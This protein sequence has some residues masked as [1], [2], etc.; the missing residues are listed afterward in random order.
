MITLD[1]ISQ[2]RVERG[3]SERLAD[4]QTLGLI[5]CFFGP[6]VVDITP[7]FM[8]KNSVLDHIHGL[9]IEYIAGRKMSSIQLRLDIPEAVEEAF[10]QKVPELGRKLRRY[11]VAHGDIHFGKY[12]IL[13]HPNNEPVLIDCG[14]TDFFQADIESPAERWV[15]GGMG[16]DYNFGLRLILSGAQTVVPRHTIEEPKAYGIDGTGKLHYAEQ[17]KRGE[18]QT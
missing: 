12:I 16:D 7:G 9:L 2:H 5:P 18:Q 13:R 14:R 3:A 11:G 6:V 8:P 15:T 4:A 10:A 17:S 1:T